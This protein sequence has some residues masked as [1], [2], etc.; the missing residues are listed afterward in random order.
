MR[1]RR[2]TSAGSPKAARTAGSERNAA[3]VLAMMRYMVSAA[4]ESRRPPSAVNSLGVKA[5]LS[6]A[7][8]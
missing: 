1:Q 4:S 5:Q 3:S 2:S 6:G 8:W 7:P